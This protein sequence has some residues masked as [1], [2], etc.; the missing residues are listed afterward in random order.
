MC[1][2]SQEGCEGEVCVGGVRL[3]GHVG[4]RCVGEV[5]K[6]GC[7]FRTSLYTYKSSKA[8]HA[9]FNVEDVGGVKGWSYHFL[10]G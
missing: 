6:C 4:G 2:R 5:C 1:G 9:S 7:I 8:I 10:E 3:V